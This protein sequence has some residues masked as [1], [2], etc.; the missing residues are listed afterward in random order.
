MQTRSVRMRVSARVVQ[1][2]RMES[3]TS[4]KTLLP[5]MLKTAR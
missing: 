2:T 3:S 4:T 1:S 5:V